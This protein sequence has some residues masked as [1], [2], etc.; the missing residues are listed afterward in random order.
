MKIVV[1]QQV[2]KWQDLPSGTVVEFKEG[3]K[4]VVVDSN[5]LLREG[6]A[7]VMLAGLGGCTYDMNI[8]TYCANESF[9]VVG[10]ITEIHIERN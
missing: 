3:E 8:T 7:L 4:C 5:S 6:R 10:K 2:K 1:E 9:K